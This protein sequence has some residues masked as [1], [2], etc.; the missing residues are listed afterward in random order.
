MYL[1]FPILPNGVLHRFTWRA[2]LNP[3]LFCAATW[4][5][6]R[7]SA[8]IEAWTFVKMSIACFLGSILFTPPPEHVLSAWVTY[9][10]G[11]QCNIFPSLHHGGNIFDSRVPSW[12]KHLKDDVC[13]EYRGGREVEI[14]GTL[15]A[16]SLVLQFRTWMLCR[17]WAMLTSLDARDRIWWFTLHG[18]FLEP[19]W[20]MRAEFW[21]ACW[22][23]VT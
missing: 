9:I 8:V 18:N 19:L 20:T 22:L 15:R 5:S 12:F 10:P 23:R 4:S 7:P 6:L 13:G 3:S 1:H 14:G 11:L 17:A 21:F 2:A 16:E